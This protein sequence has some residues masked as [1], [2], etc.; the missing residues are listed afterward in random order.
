MLNVDW[1]RPYKYVEYSV[2]ALYI[3]ILNLPRHLRYLKENIFLVGIIPGPC[4][5]SLHMNSI[6]GPLVNDLLKLWRGVEMNTCEGLKKFKQCYCAHHVICQQQE[7]EWF[8]GHWA[9]KGCSRCLKSFDTLNFGKKPDYSG[10]VRELWPK[11][12]NKNHREQ[13]IK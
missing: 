10:F 9:Q 11:R 4:E 2:G 13:G 6:L 7:F 3:A 1:F 12:D 5:P 8:L